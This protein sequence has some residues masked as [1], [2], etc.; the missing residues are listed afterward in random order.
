MD[1][2]FGYCMFFV[3][4]LLTITPAMCRRR[5]KSDSSENRS[6]RRRF[7]VAVLPALPTIAGTAV[8]PWLFLALLA[9]YGAAELA[10]YAITKDTCILYCYCK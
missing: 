7:A 3:F 2:K 8:V 1:K 10:R 4:L 6:E 5:A 9:V